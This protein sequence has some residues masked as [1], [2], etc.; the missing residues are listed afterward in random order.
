M[1]INFAYIKNIDGVVKLSVIDNVITFGSDII[2]II[3]LP[4]VLIDI[5]V[6]V[7]IISIYT[8]I[9]PFIE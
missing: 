1:L 9:S 2:N 4:I 3:I 6:R 7:S 8:I 5:I